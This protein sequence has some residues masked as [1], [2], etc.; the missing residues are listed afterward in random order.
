M[1]E[2]TTPQQFAK[3]DDQQKYAL[4]AKA[5]LDRNNAVFLAREL[6]GANAMERQRNLV[7][8]PLNALRN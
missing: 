5:E 3:L 8:P 6:S 1:K 4:L 2:L 7:E